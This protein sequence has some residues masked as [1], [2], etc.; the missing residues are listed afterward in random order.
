MEKG[1]V[2]SKV[3]KYLTKYREY[4]R[5][6]QNSQE[7]DRGDALWDK[8]DKMWNRM[9]PDEQD[10]VCDTLERDHEKD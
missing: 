4:M 6:D 7:S 9:S 2:M 5:L 3:N 8:L 1:I 10:R